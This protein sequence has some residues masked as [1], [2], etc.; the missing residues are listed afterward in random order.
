FP[1]IVVGTKKLR[2]PKFKDLDR[3]LEA[4]MK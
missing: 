4:S 2:N 3:W 1:T